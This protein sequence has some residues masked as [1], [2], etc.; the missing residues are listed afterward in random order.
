MRRAPGAILAAGRP[1]PGSGNRLETAFGEG[2][3]GGDSALSGPDNS[4]DTAQGAPGQ[5]GNLA[6][7]CEAAAP[8]QRGLAPLSC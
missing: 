6:P 1:R 8:L 3:G 7:P 4:G 2:P 5:V